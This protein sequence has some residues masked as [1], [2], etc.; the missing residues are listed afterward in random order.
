LSQPAARIGDMHLCPMQTPA[1]VPIPHVGGPILPPGAP[2]VLIGGQPAACVG[3]MAIC[4]GPPDV[5]VM[6]STGVM[7]SGRPAA[8]MGDMCAHLGAIVGGYPT[9]LIGEVGGGGGAGGAAAAGVTAAAAT[10][11]AAKASGAA[12]V[13]TNCATKTVLGTL[14]DHPALRYPAP[15][16]EDPERP[17]WVEIELVD[18]AGKP[19]PHERWR[20]VGSD[21]M[22]RE[23]WTD[24]QGVARVEGLKPGECTITFPELAP[25]A[26]KSA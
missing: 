23:G 15:G 3:D 5:I 12:F 13:E 8:R 19:V 6:G 9:V 7:I 25:Q 24:A 14:G 16:K 1:V 20:V 2:T 26:W 10:M 21:G 17:S 4:V 22:V 18:D 11:R